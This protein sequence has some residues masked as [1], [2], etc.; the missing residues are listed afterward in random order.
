MFFDIALR[1]LT[2]CSRLKK[3][4]VSILSKTTKKAAKSIDKLFLLCYINVSM[5]C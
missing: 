1:I 3:P 2:F 5:Q 4:G